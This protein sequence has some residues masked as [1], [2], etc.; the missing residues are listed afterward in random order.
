MNMDDKKRSKKGLAICLRDMGDGTSR[1]FIDDV[2]ANQS[3]NPISWQYNSFFTYTPNFE[4][5]IIDDM[6]LTDEEFKNIG[7]D[8]VARLL[9]LNKRIK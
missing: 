8:V 1:I 7:I 4:N 3:E 9:A 5:E 6:A 2:N